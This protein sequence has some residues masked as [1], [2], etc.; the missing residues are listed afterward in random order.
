MITESVVTSTRL[1]PVSI[2]T[3]VQEMSMFGARR[4]RSTKAAQLA[5][6]GVSDGRFRTEVWDQ[7]DSLMPE[8]RNHQ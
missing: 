8:T 5:K 2:V 6:R 4:R 3:S 7:L 1:S